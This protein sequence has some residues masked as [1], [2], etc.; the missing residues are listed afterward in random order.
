MSD[1]DK[2]AL[3]KGFTDL[4]NEGLIIDI[5]M[6]LRPCIERG[7]IITEQIVITHRVKEASNAQSTQ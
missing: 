7:D 1:I 4:I 2:E 3:I 6:G 5:Q